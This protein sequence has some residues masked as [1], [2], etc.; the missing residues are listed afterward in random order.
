MIAREDDIMF[1]VIDRMW[2]RQA[3]MIVVVR[4][5]GVPRARSVVGVISKEHIADSVAASVRPYTDSPRSLR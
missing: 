5:R 4:G 1:H 3:S 2:R